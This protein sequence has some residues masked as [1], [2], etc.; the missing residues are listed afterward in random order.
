[1]IVFLLSA[2]L[3]YAQSL[4]SEDAE[5]AYIEALNKTKKNY[6]IALAKELETSDVVSLHQIK[7]DCAIKGDNFFDEL[8]DNT[9]S[10][11]NLAGEDKLKLV[12]LLQK[13]LLR[14]EYLETSYKFF[15]SHGVLFYKNSRLLFEATFCPKSSLFYMKY[16]DGSREVLRFSKD[17][18]TLM[19]KML[20]VPEE[21]KARYSKWVE[22]LIVD[23][24]SG[25]KIRNRQ[26]EISDLQAKLST[27]DAKLRFLMHELFERDR[28]KKG[29]QN[30][31]FDE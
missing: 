30:G 1:M 23:M 13:E 21:E 2:K 19:N 7:F 4:K 11:K 31:P 15:P 14:S 17:L 12:K 24:G 5:E 8:K 22:K 18:Q 28:K 29:L 27:E 25:E 20:P 16:P 26:T 6:R 10:K 3:G 9:L